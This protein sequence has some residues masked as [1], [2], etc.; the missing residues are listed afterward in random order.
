[1]ARTE[2]FA[3]PNRR[4]ISLRCGKDRIDMYAVAG[5]VTAGAGVRITLVVQAVDGHVGDGAFAARLDDLGAVH[6][7][8][9]IRDDDA[10]AALADK[11]YAVRPLVDD[12]IRVTHRHILRGLVI[13]KAV[14]DKHRNRVV[15]DIEGV[16]CEVAR[17]RDRE[18]MPRPA[19][20]HGEG[21]RV[22]VFQRG[23]A[24]GIAPCV[25]VIERDDQILDGDLLA[26][27]GGCGYAGAHIQ[28]SRYRRRLAAVVDFVGAVCLEDE[29]AA[30]LVE[31]VRIG[32]DPQRALFVHAQLHAHENKV[33]SCDR[34]A[35]GQGEVRRHA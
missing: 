25:I 17:L 23:P 26:D 7:V 5:L 10:V 4:E 32:N 6:G 20:V 30:P 16:P 18:E 31:I 14:A 12:R 21:V 15:H 1:M 24:L 29:P 34:D 3:V 22:E 33:R 19:L 9:L 27:I 8:V 11:R 35:A 2:E 13:V 28:P